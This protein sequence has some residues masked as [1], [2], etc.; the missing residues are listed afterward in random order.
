VEPAPSS[1]TIKFGPY[2]LDMR[3]GELRKNGS[4]IR[5]QEKPLRVLA[6]L[7]EQQGQVVTRDEL[8]K[9]LWP[10]DT[11]V[12]F[13]TG[14]N[15]AV[16]KL[17]DAL[18]DTAEKPR[19]IETIPRR[20]YRF[21]PAVEIPGN[22][23]A[24]TPVAVAPPVEVSKSVTAPPPERNAE[25]PTQVSAKKRP[26]RILV[27]AAGIAA[28]AAVAF[29]LWW[30]TPL[31]EP[32]ILNV[33]PVTTTAKQDFLVRPASDGV[34]IFYVERNG[35]HYDLM[36]VPATGGESQQMAAPFPNSLIWDVS[37]DGS[38]YLLT[39]FV[40]RGEPSPLW[41]W[42]AT[43][44]PAIRLSDLVSGSAVWSPDGKLIAG[45]SGH[46]L[47]LADSDGGN[48]HI[49]ATF[50]EEPD[51]PVWSPDGTRLRFTLNDPDR[52][53]AAIWEIRKNGTGLHSLLPDWKNSPRLC[54]GE[55]TPDGRYFVFV[56]AARPS[57]LWALRE[58]GSWWRRSPRG[59]FLL[60]AE[61]GG[62]WSPFFGRDGQ[63]L[64]FY[65]DDQ[66]QTLERV[67]MKSG[68]SSALLPDSHLAAMASFSRDGEWISY[69][70][71]DSGLA[72][73]SRPDGHDRRQL[74]SAPSPSSFPRWSPDGTMLVLAGQHSGEPP[75]AYL[76]SAEGGRA[77]PIV[78]GVERL[79]DPDWS[80]D[81]SSIVLAQL[82]PPGPGKDEDSV[83]KIV[84]LKTRHMQTVP[85]SEHL[86]GPRWSP[87][88]RWIAALNNSTHTLQLYDLTTKKWR[89]AAQGDVLGLPVWSPDSAYVYYQDLL[90][91]G[92]PVFRVS[93]SSGRIEKAA[94]FQK[95]L[96]SGV[97]RCPFFGL[98]PD[99]SAL[100]AFERGNA[101]IYGAT[102]SLP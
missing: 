3:A 102:V 16:S 58:Q 42:P 86:S 38:Q 85:G 32:H 24:E 65:S 33:Y 20:G 30:F 7:A 55:W 89:A 95:I 18:S 98:T 37:P 15:T 76:I 47:F 75:N 66:Q 61:P 56:D 93:V 73:R 36:Q 4:R 84:D 92:E 100:V 6:A 78:P 23:R 101:D 29:A 13:E 96:S 68:Q 10:D 19:F 63:H 81:G 46:D 77:E 12:D 59:P 25:S 49:L 54:C 67:D 1:P 70:Q 53:T 41:S 91:A 40:H 8:R 50:R 74:T 62:S 31:P 99:G 21:V 44:G 2:L 22:G 11:F 60:A 88:G 82:L 48:K 97:H 9:R 26:S 34:R 45:H 39:S 80:G 90:G 51:S 87:D 5:L 52:N 14:L 79:V 43:G 83:L 17:R 72:W 94:D 35:D 64:Y 57:R 27:R 71:L 69:V 28:I